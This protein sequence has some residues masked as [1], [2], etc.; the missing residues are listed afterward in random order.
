[1]AYRLPRGAKIVVDT[2][3]HKSGRRE[4]DRGTQIGLYFATEPIE[5]EIRTIAT[6]NMS[7][8]I[9][10]GAAAHKV[11]TAWRAPQDVELLGLMPHMHLIGREALVTLE[12]PDKTRRELL[13]IKDW[14]FNWQESYGFKEPIALSKG[15][16]ILYTAV[17]DNSDANPNNPSHPA[18]PVIT[19]VV[20]ATRTTC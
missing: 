4:T 6:L 1:V 13:S 3:Y 10:P 11:S 17:Y 5:K 12:A 8:K 16:R 2:H 19:P 18:K 7:F 9:P 20:V 15:S 14:D